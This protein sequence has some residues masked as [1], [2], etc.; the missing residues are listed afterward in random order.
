MKELFTHKISDTIR[1]I[2]KPGV[3]VSHDLSWPVI[4][5]NDF[6]ISQDGQHIVFTE[7]SHRFADRDCF[8]AMVEHRADGR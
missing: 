5:F 7:P 6:D 3:K 4:H 8:Y 1:Q 2:L